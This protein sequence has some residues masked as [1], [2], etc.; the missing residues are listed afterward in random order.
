MKS[1]KELITQTFLKHVVL[2]LG[3]AIVLFF[4][5]FIALNLYTHHGE[6]FSVPDFSGLTIE[7]VQQLC[8][9]KDL[10]YEVTD[11]VFYENR[12]KG[13]VVEQNPPADFKVKRNRTIFLT[14]NASRPEM[15]KMPNVRDVS[16]V[17]AKASLETAGLKVG[18]LIYVEH[19]AK[20]L[21]LKQKYNGRTIPPGKEIAKG[22]SIDLELGR[23]NPEDGGEGSPKTTV[24]D[25][26]GLT[27]DQALGKATDMYLNLG[28]VIFDRSVETYRDSLEAVVYRQ[29]PTHSR[30]GGVPYGSYI[31][32]WL[33]KNKSKMPA[34]N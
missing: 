31:S 6:A 2:A 1:F 14:M 26:T 28:A 32:I 18:K 16:L 23:G 17:Q 34:E 30:A 10:R 25:L 7:E 22:S 8:D 33:T 29:D 11:S 24:P 3:I 15:V 5:T 12:K 9:D 13:T 19:W 27:K 20:N 21:V 4:G